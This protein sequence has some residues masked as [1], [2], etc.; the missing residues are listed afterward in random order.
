[1]TQKLDQEQLFWEAMTA[2]QKAIKQGVIVVED[3]MPLFYRAISRDTEQQIRTEMN[4]ISEQYAKQGAD[5]I[6]ERLRKH[7]AK[8]TVNYTELSK[9]YLL[10]RHR[11]EKLEQGLEELDKAQSALKLNDWVLKSLVFVGFSLISLSSL[12]ILIALVNLLGGPV[13]TRLWSE[14]FLGSLDLNAISWQG[15]VSVIIKLLGSALLGLL[16]G[17]L[18]FAPWVV[19]NWLLA[20]LPY[21]YR[22]PFDLDQWRNC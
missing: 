20:K 15:L 6:N 5:F 8:D 2:L 21:K 12:G 19:F 14:V 1:M 16:G 22:K 9:S 7:L 10:F 11:F 13:L 18:I 3:D 4:A 17:A